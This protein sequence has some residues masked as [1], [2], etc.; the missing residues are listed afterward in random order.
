MESCI[1]YNNLTVAANVNLEGLQ[2][3]ARFLQI[4][5]DVS[6]D[7][8]VKLVWKKIRPIRKRSMY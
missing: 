1:S 7:E 6:K 3:L 2:R 5:V 4:D 8:L